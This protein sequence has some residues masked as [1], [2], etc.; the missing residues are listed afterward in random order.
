MG[1]FFV[2][3]HIMARMADLEFTPSP[4][5]ILA[6]TST[7]LA[8][9]ARRGGNKA[10]PTG[11]LT[12]TVVDADGNEIATATP[13][14]ADGTITATLTAAQ[15]A[16]VNL[17]TATW[18]GLVF[19]GA[20]AIEVISRHEVIGEY[21]FTVEE[22]RRA[23]PAL[24][25]AAKFS[26]ADIRAGRERV[27]QAL[28]K[29]LK[30]SLGRRYKR[31]SIDVV[32]AG[33]MS[34]GDGYVSEVRAMSYRDRGSTVSVA[35]DAGE[36]A[37]ITPDDVGYLIGRNWYV[38]TR[39][40]VS[41]VAGLTPIPLE[42]KRAGILLLAHEIVRTNIPRSAIQQVEQTGTYALATP[43]LRGSIFGIPDVDNIVKRYGRKEYGLA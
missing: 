19:D 23:D 38:G 33:E 20:P 36:L 24:A 39:V 10:T 6:G 41:Y 34:L 18:G 29:E 40:T 42:I 1:A 28:E 5:V 9:E 35:L 3:R 12:L 25:G 8:L 2:P 27:T 14:A 30:F 13:T 11:T 26:D 43:G 31:A 32:H 16:D 22:A 21:L 15:T 37:Y 17:L 7:T 4:P